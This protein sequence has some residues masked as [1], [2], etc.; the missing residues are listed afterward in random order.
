MTLLNSPTDLHHSF[1]RNLSLLSS[2]KL[3][4]YLKCSN[5]LDIKQSLNIR[6]EFRHSEWFQN[7]KRALFNLGLLWNILKTSPVA[8]PILTSNLFL[9]CVFE[10]L[11]GPAKRE[12]WLQ[13]RME[14]EATTDSWLTLALKAL[15]LIHSR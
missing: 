8:I 1:S 4:Y 11:L 12:T 3:H 7:W 5:L 10:G 2:K 6:T 14:L 9:C 13:L 15:T